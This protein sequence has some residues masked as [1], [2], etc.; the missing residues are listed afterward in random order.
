VAVERSKQRALKVGN[1]EA[2][3]DFLD[4]Q[5]AVRAFLLLTQKTQPGEVYNL[6]SGVGHQVGE[7]LD[8]LLAMTKR[9]I[10]VEK[11]PSRMR[12]ADDPVL[13]GDNSR[14]RALGWEPRIPLRQTLESLLDYWRQEGSADI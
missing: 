9:P 6:C 13:I 4:V 2:V 11:D 7:V 14:L 5:D 1:L 12:P 10:P 8:I 3:R